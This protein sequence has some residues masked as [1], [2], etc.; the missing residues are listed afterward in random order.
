MDSSSRR[1]HL[2]ATSSS[3]RPGSG[4]VVRRGMPWTSPAGTMVDVYRSRPLYA[5]LVAAGF[6]SSTCAPRCSS[7]AASVLLFT[8]SM[9]LGIGRIVGFGVGLAAVLFSFANPLLATWLIFSSPTGSPWPYGRPASPAPRCSSEH[10]RPAMAGASGCCSGCPVVHAPAGES[11]CRS[12]SA[13]A[14]AALVARRPEW[15]R[16]GLGTGA[17]ALATA[18][19]HGVQLS[20]RAADRDRRPAGPADQALP[21]AGGSRSA[22]VDDRGRRGAGRRPARADAGRR[23]GALGPGAW[24]AWSGSSPS[25]ARGR[26][27]RSWRPSPSCRSRTWSIRAVGGA[28]N[29]GS[30]LGQ[31]APGNGDGIRRRRHAP[32]DERSHRTPRADGHSLTRCTPEPLNSSVIETRSHLDL[33]SRASRM[34]ELARRSGTACVG[35]PEG[36]TGHT[37][38]EEFAHGGAAQRSLRRDRSTR[39]ASSARG[40]RRTKCDPTAGSSSPARR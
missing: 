35:L 17:A 16:L 22:D 27:P 14:L 11:S 9:A 40:R 10:W 29:H 3:S 4:R 18:L 21:A 28:A 12:C 38:P 23:P 26:L 8:V 13:L 39:R 34:G 36:G 2:P 25:G 33:D 6:R 7:S 37:R 19:L 32:P 24:S 1:M 5:L 15:K 20:A 30:D 31:R